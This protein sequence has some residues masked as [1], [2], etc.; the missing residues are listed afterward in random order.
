MRINKQFGRNLRF[1]RY[2]SG[3][4]MRGNGLSQSELA[5]KLGVARKTIVFWESG[6][7]PSARKLTDLCEFFSH[8]LKL[9][10]PI[11]PDDMLTKNIEDYFMVVPERGEVHRVKPE[12]KKFLRDLY[13]RADKLT[14]NDLEKIMKII[15]E[16]LR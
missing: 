14:P 15:D 6:Q 16:L 2:A 8:H 9:E 7:V 10:E 3:V 12:F 5:K 13:A 11:T 1:L 4:I